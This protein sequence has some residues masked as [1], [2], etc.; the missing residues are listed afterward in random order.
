MADTYNRLVQ[1]LHC[2][3]IYYTYNLYICMIT[4]QC[5]LFNSKVQ[6]YSCTVVQFLL[7][8]FL[9]FHSVASH[10]CKIYLKLKRYKPVLCLYG[11]SSV[12]I[13]ACLIRS[14]I[15]LFSIQLIMFLN[16]II[17]ILQWSDVHM[18]FSSMCSITCARSV[19]F[20][21]TITYEI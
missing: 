6:L 18:V 15:V 2:W 21:I 3:E 9:G 5:I 4:Y 8:T 7:V 1:S 20:F 19:S 11:L 10:T 12:L 16:I 14:D 13:L 17:P